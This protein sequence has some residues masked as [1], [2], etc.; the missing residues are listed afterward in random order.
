MGSSSFR[1]RKAGF[2][3]AR[4][5]LACWRQSRRTRGLIPLAWRHMLKAIQGGSP[6]RS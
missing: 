2:A 5:L 3:Y 6:N 4:V 1:L